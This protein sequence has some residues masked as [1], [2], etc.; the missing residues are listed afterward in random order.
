[1]EAVIAS[2]PL[3]R[4]CQEYLI[5]L[6][7]EGTTIVF[8]ELLEIELQEAA[9]QLGLKERHPKDWKRYRSDGRARPRAARLAN[10]ALSA[11]EDVVSVVPHEVLDVG[12]V[13]ELVPGL[14]SNYGIASYDAIH[15]ATAIE[16]DTQI[17]VT[18]D[19]GFGSL[20]EE[21]IELYVDL[22]R[23]SSCRRRR[24]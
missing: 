15:A 24:R 16:S 7:A 1:V 18:I 5:R 6:A 17:L 3:H 13:A 14:M 8:N 12:D 9:F 22:S 20:P 11:W 2:Q 19:A 21:Q 4:A 10:G 23:V